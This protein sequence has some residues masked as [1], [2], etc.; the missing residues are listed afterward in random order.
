[1]TTVQLERS[2]QLKKLFSYPIG[3]GSHYLPAC[4][5]QPQPSTLLS[6]P[7]TYIAD[8]LITVHFDLVQNF[9]EDTVLQLTTG[10]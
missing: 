9:I 10:N 6:V 7:D 8:P 1:M 4:S 5:S 2:G 3:N